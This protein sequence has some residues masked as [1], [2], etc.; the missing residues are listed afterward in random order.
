MHEIT[1]TGEA[2]FYTRAAMA[3]TGAARPYAL[4]PAH[5]GAPEAAPAGAVAPTAAQP[6]EPSSRHRHLPVSTFVLE[7]GKVRCMHD[8]QKTSICCFAM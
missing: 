4:S 6:A 7:T 1:Q 8:A 5:A 2:G 3:G